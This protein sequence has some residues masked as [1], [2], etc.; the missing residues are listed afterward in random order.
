MICVIVKVFNGMM[1]MMI[2]VILLIF[3]HLWRQC[4]RWLLVAVTVSRRVRVI[5]IGMFIGRRRSHVNFLIMIGG[6]VWRGIIRAGIDV[7]LVTTVVQMVMIVMGLLIQWDRRRGT[8]MII[9]AA[10]AIRRNSF[11]RRSVIVATAVLLLKLLL[12]LLLLLLSG[13]DV[14]VLLLMVHLFSVSLRTADSSPGIGVIYPYRTLAVPVALLNFVVVISMQLAAAITTVTITT[15]ITAIIIIGML[16]K[17]LLRTSRCIL[18][19][20]TTSL[21]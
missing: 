7:I 20:L 2:M 13:I 5:I 8:I 17:L 10:A 21:I 1:M 12:L 15:T 9:I 16:R 3:N 19:M 14:A 11:V 6:S 18:Q 4:Y